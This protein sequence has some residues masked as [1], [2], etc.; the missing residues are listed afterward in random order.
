MSETTSASTLP[1]P[2]EATVSPPAC[3][4]SSESS[5][6]SFTGLASR[7]SRRPVWDLARSY[8]MVHRVAVVRR[9]HCPA[10]ISKTSKATAQA[11][12][13]FISHRVASRSASVAEAATYTFSQPR[14]SAC[15]AMRWLITTSGVVHSSCA[16]ASPSRSKGCPG[17]CCWSPSRPV[18]AG[19]SCAPGWSLRRPVVAPG[20]GRPRP[21]APGATL[22]QGL[23]EQF[24]A[25]IAAQDEHRSATHRL[26]R[27]QLQKA[28]RCPCVAVPV[29]VPG[30]SPRAHGRSLCRRPRYP[31]RPAAVRAA[32][33]ANC[34]ALALTKI[35]R[36]AVPAAASARRAA[37]LSP[38]P[39][40]SSAGSAPGARALSG[41][42]HRP[43]D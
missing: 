23:A 43:S 38:G 14:P 8:W 5:A 13:S 33:N 2:A 37:R 1:L 40:I 28:P 31:R 22:A 34:T 36:S 18:P 30:P 41:S 21:A 26:Q 42:V 25:T 39:R 15:S 24:P 27:R 7:R 12:S 9:R 16:P 29:S 17:S 19:T 20:G 6:A 35:S 3:R 10:D 4:D 11:T 32:G